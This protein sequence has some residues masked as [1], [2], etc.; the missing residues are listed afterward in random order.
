MR[1]LN[2]N[3]MNSPTSTRYSA[4]HSPRAHQR[5]DRLSS[6]VR[7]LAC[8]VIASIT[9]S[10]V[11]QPAVPGMT[12]TLYGEFGANYLPVVLAF[13]NA[14]YLYAASDNNTAGGV[15]VR[16][17]LPGGG[18]SVAYSLNAVPDPD[19]ILFDVT[20]SFSGVPGALLLGCGIP[21]TTNG[22]IRAV[23]PNGTD[24]I[25]SGPSAILNNCGPLAFDSTGRL[26]ASVFGNRTIVRFTGTTPSVFVTM[27]GAVSPANLE[28]DDL[29]RVWVSCSDG[30]VRRYSTSG[31][32]QATIP[33]GGV[34]PGLGQNRL[35]G[36]F[37]PGM[38]VT[39]RTTGVLSHVTAADTLVA[40]GTGFV[41]AFN[42]IFDA[43]GSIYVSD[44]TPGRIWK[45]E[46]LSIADQPES[47][48]ACA[49]GSATFSVIAAGTPP[50]SY[51]WQVADSGVV[52][53]W[54]DLSNGSLTIDGSPTCGV[55]SGAAASTI[56]ISLTCAND[57]SVNG[58]MYRCI[59]SNPCR[60]IISEV[61]TL[62]II[63]APTL[64]CDSLDFNNDCSVYD[65]LDIDAYLSVYGEG[66]CVPN[67]ALCND[68]DFN[69]DGS[70]FD[71]C[72][73][74]SFL[75]VYSEGPCTLCGL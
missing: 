19:G 70:L 69:N 21:S 17:L 11:A 58:S 32:L 6:S 56:T 38:Y 7:V 59:V 34:Y 18:T 62:D 51:Q 74:D 13:D 36:N 1:N 33:V 54:A 65:P 35:A 68:I 2:K 15:Q 20:G 53:G 57:D 23:R 44:Y 30:A 75:L 37:A 10:A 48:S 46:C 40:T 3:T 55:V 64:P 67:T 14:G 27:P 9:V 50:F 22:L 16:R 24:F 60:S 5:R 29:D 49:I 43:D 66:P 39:H 52:G 42:P 12:T 28:V 31:T 63:G 25:V 8:V 47:T 45:I 41:N 26:Y 73:I 71:P 72:D 4:A 61:A